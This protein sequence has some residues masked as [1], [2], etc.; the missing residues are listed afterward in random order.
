MSPEA[1]DASEFDPAEVE[2][3]IHL[4]AG[5]AYGY[6]ATCGVKIDYRSAETAAKAATQLMEKNRTSR[7]R[8][9]GYP[10]EAYPCPWCLGW[11]IGRA[12][13]TDER[14]YWTRAAVTVLGRHDHD[15][16]ET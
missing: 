5:L 15:Q 7:L 4:I 3:A 2:R 6:N 9:P 8:S 1:P 12:L 16:P 14:R 10:L 11:H 13:T